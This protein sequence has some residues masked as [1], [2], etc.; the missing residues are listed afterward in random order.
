[1]TFNSVTPHVRG[2]E[3][4]W[5]ASVEKYSGLLIQLSV[6]IFPE[7]LTDYCNCFI[8]VTR[9]YTSRRSVTT[10]SGRAHRICS[11]KF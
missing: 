4:I 7:I 8:V 6:N 3:D 11:N 10:G 2:R 1:M 9:Q 5:L